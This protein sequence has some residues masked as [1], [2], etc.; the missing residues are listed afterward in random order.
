MRQSKY[1][2]KVVAIYM[3]KQYTCIRNQ[4]IAYCREKRFLVYFLFIYIYVLP[5]FPFDMFSCVN[6]AAYAMPVKYS[7]SYNLFNNILH[8]FNI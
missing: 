8:A 4:A 3:S 1:V 6:I 2:I 7:M 5:I